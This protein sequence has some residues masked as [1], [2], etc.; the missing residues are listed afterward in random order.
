MDFR[1]EYRDPG[2]AARAGSLTTDHGAVKTP[3]FMPVGTAGAV[4]AVHVK[5]LRDE[6]GAE[7][8]LS[9]TYHLYLRPGTEVIARAGGLH[10]FTGWDR[11]ILT[12]SGGFQIYSLAD[13]RKFTDEGVIFQSHIDG[14]RHHFT[15][16]AAVD[17]QRALGADII[18]AFDEC[19]PYP[20][21][22]KYA[23]EAMNRTHQWAEQ[24]VKYFHNN[25][26]IPNNPN[27]PKIFGIIQGS[28]FKV[29]REK[30]AKYISSL[31][32]RS[33]DHTICSIEADADIDG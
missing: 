9:N 19:T 20:A 10:K 32:S 2:S 24:A 27:R 14:S 29:L 7:I 25:L 18:M 8:M 12:D 22:K 23:T 4:K 1:V 6:I 33:S 31:P 13:I 3:F 11:P 5:D 21:T 17:I 15:P 16:E 28:T 30:S 26:N